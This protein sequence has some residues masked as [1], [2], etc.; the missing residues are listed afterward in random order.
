MSTVFN[1]RLVQ[2]WAHDRNLIKGSNPKQ[3]FLKLAEEGGEVAEAILEFDKDKLVDAIGDTTVVIIII[4]SQLN[5]EPTNFTSCTYKMDKQP[6]DFETGVKTK[7]A[8]AIGLHVFK[9]LKDVA[10]DI[11]RDRDPSVSMHKVM[12]ALFLL[13]EQCCLDFSECLRKAY[14]EIKDR[15]GTMIDGVF[16]KDE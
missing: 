9:N 8:L 15:T 10:G 1:T 14:M 2:Q 16:V 4:A 11:A 7:E 3:Q 12:A 5:M 13:C 6:K